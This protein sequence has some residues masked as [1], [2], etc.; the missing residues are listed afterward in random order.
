MRRS[1]ILAAGFFACLLVARTFAQEYRKSVTLEVYLPEGARLFIAGQEV[2]ARAPMCRFVS[3]PLPPGKYIYTV[4]AII[5][6]PNGS[7]TITHRLDIR[8]GDFE[9]IDLRAPGKRP[10]ADVEYEPT[11]QAVVDA[12]LRLA[13]VTPRTWS[14]TSAAATDASP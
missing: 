14:G 6:G 10:I 1:L 7:R 9:S 8:P 12:L 5:P 2:M 13:R 3:P 11:P 4:Q